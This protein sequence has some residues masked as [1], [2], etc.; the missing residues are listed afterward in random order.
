[1]SENGINFEYV[2][3]KVSCPKKSMTF[4]KLTNFTEKINNREVYVE[5]SLI[6]L[7]N[8]TISHRLR[9]PI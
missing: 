7:I 5:E 4:L 8:S 9:T 3:I 2:Q 6:T 1:M